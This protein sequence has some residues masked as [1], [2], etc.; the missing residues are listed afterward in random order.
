MGK[1]ID[2]YSQ[3]EFLTGKQQDRVVKKINKI[4]VIIADKQEEL[5]KLNDLLNLPIKAKKE[6]ANDNDQV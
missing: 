1:L 5:Q 2:N 4:E 6:K 3:K